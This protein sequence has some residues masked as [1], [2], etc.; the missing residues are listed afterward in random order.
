MIKQITDFKVGDKFRI[1]NNFANIYKVKT[2]EVYKVYSNDVPP[3]AVYLM[4]HA[5][6]HKGSYD[7]QQYCFT[8]TNFDAYGDAV[9]LITE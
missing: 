7:G 5:I 3:K 6:D 4:A 9:K 8:Q 1:G 2:F